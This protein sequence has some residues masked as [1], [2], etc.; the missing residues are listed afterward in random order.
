MAETQ[1]TMPDHELGQDMGTGG[2]QLGR[3]PTEASMTT[4]SAELRPDDPDG[5]VPPVT[6]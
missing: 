3:P 5:E 4:G 2:T 1:E 6:E